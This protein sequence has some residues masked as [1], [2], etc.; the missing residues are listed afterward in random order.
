MISFYRWI[1]HLPVR[2]QFWMWDVKGWTTRLLTTRGTPTQRK[3][4]FCYWIG[5]PRACGCCSILQSVSDNSG[6]RS[7]GTYLSS[8]SKIWKCQ[9]CSLGI[10]VTAIFLLC[11][12]RPG[13]AN[14]NT[15]ALSRQYE[16]QVQDH[17]LPSQEDGGNV[18]ISSPLTWTLHYIIN[19]KTISQG[20][21][22]FISH[23]SL[24]YEVAE[25]THIHSHL[26]LSYGVSIYFIC[27]HPTPL[28]PVSV[29][30]SSITSI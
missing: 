13:I 5:R 22:T 19:L 21:W 9:D 27:L 30:S 11:D 29:P 6:N 18:T 25:L 15:D 14:A 16:D 17:D 4:L 1:P 23:L 8:D 7:Q 12:I 2:V 3:A 28:F 24:S 20:C 10:Q 26:S